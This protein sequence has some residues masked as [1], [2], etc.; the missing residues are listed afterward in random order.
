MFRK[1]HHCGFSAFNR[2]RY[3]LSL[4]NKFFLCSSA[5]A[6]QGKT[7]VK[8]SRVLDSDDDDDAERG[9]VK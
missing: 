7:S 5:A 9:N 3:T 6:V 1:K 2:S 4:D 8:R